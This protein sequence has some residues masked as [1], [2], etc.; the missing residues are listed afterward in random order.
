MINNIFFK[1]ILELDPQNMEA[2]MNLGLVHLKL[3]NY[4]DSIQFYNKAIQIMPNDP[5]AHM[6]KLENK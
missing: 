1:K 4:P 2:Y 3:K 6:S 5:C